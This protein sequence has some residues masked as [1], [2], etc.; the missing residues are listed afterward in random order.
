M[1]WYAVDPDSAISDSWCRES[2]TGRADWP[3]SRHGWNRHTPASCRGPRQ[4]DYQKGAASLK[5][6]GIGDP[7]AHFK[8]KTIKAKG[9]VKEVDG[10]PR[11]EIDDAKQITV[12]K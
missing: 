10:I 4:C 3:P 8:G 2:A 9:T 1:R 11:I 6:T 5:E 12:S 7:A